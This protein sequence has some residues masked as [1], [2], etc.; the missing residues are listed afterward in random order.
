[1]KPTV[2][3]FSFLMVAVIVATLSAC[4]AESPETSRT[5]TLSAEELGEV[6]AKIWL[7]PEEADDILATYDMTME[8]FEQALDDVSSNSERSR[9]YSVSFEMTQQRAD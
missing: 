8:E 9:R 6:G 5:V 3:L 7:K 2:N 4:Q 1:M